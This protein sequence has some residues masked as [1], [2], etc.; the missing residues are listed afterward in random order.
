MGAIPEEMVSNSG[1][2]PWHRTGLVV[3]RYL[4]AGDAYWMGGL[5][6]EVSKVPI[7]DADTYEEVPERYQLKAGFPASHSK[8]DATKPRV[9]VGTKP[10]IVSAQYEVIENVVMAMS[11]SIGIC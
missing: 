6:Y 7:L 8:H 4:S 9:S 2:T 1:M 10:Q 11:F 5:D 3:D